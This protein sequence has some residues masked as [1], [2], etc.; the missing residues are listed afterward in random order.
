M[1]CNDIEKLPSCLISYFIRFLGFCWASLTDRSRTIS[2]S[3]EQSTFCA[4]WCAL[5]TRQIVPEIPIY[6]CTWLS[7]Y[8]FSAFLNWWEFANCACA[9]ALWHDPVFMEMR[10]SDVHDWN[11]IRGVGGFSYNGANQ[12]M[13]GLTQIEIGEICRSGFLRDVLPLRFGNWKI[14]IYIRFEQ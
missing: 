11:W 10:H 14:L 1:S 9:I 12:C 7:K 3:M 6:L 5:V 13:H 8:D 2:P 4:T